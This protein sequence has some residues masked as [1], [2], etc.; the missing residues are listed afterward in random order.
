MIQGKGG[1]F[2]PELTRIGAQRSLVYLRVSLVQPSAD[3]LAGY[4]AI[5]F[6]SPQGNRI[7]GIKRNEDDFS[8][9]VMDMEEN[10]H[11][12]WKKDLKEIINGTDSLMPAYGDS[13]TA[14]EIIDLVAFLSSL[15]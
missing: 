11:S 13:L 2:G 8:V 4:E 12:H 5:A 7:T 10:L 9:Q 3:I 14:K 6:I 15:Q 1:R